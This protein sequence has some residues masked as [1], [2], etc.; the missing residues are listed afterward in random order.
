MCVEGGG[1][2]GGG[3]VVWRSGEC[4][5]LFSSQTFFL[6]FCLLMTAGAKVAWFAIFSDEGFWG[7]FGG[8]IT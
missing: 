8:L 6:R 2:G 3:G 4:F 7:P 1:G 5:F